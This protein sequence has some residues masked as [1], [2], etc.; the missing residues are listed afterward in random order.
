MLYFIN[1]KAISVV[2]TIVKKWIKRMG[3]YS[4]TAQAVKHIIS[5]LDG[6]IIKTKLLKFLYLSDL[7]YR[8]LTGNQITDLRYV[9]WDE[10]PY[11]SKVND[12]IK[13][14][15]RKGLIKEEKHSLV[16]GLG[17]YFLY[18][19]TDKDIDMA[20][21]NAKKEVIDNIINTYYHLELKDLLENIV[22][23]TKPMQKAIKNK[24]FGNVL[25]MDCVNF[26]CK[27]MLEELNSKY[28]DFN[29]AAEI[30]PNV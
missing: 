22:Y 12:Y 29:I 6:R 19:D 27:E 11:D 7:E 25:D 2:V 16:S 17:D 30:L 3:K 23:Q 4:E 5:R 1:A 10:G 21:P 20:L 26:E 18:F 9:W 24:A 28:E 15:H 14:L 13:Q 8:K